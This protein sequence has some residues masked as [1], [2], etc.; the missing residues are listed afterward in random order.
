[1]CAPAIAA[2]RCAS[3]YGHSLLA[4]EAAAALAALIL[5]AR[6]RGLW[7]AAVVAVLACMAA[8]TAT[9]AGTR[10]EAHRILD[11]AKPQEG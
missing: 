5:V 8:A 4:A 6:R 7:I 3:G 10:A 9:F 11:G 1:M 2:E